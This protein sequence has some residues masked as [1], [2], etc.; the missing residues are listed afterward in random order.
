MSLRDGDVQIEGLSS[1]YFR[2][3]DQ[4]LPR[5]CGDGRARVWAVEVIAMKRL[6]KW[7]AFLAVPLLLLAV[8][9]A[10]GSA[11]K[12][13]TIST[14]GAIESFSVDG[15]RVAF[16]ARGVPPGS[17]NKVLVW[18]VQTR[19]IKRVIGPNTCS[20][21]SSPAGG[22]P[23]L[24]VAGTRIAWIVGGASLGESHESL[25]TASLPRPSERRLEA[26]SGAGLDTEGNPGN[27]IGH[28]VGSGSLIVVNR[29]TTDAAGAVT[30]SELDVVGTKSL[31]RIVSGPDALFASSVD[32]GRIA[33]L[34][35]DGGVGV[36]SGSG[37]LLREVRPSSAKE[38]PCKATPWS[39][40]RRLERWRSTTPAPAPTSVAGRCRSGQPASMSP[41][42]L[43]STSKPGSRPR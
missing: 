11:P 10:S 39:S 4:K 31:R 1:P 15:M 34:R 27:W 6:V 35:A 26:A 2:R 12:P 8:T 9:S 20:A 23:E 19:M 38:S 3:L 22:V 17:C 14:G 25:R 33:V 41:A 13:G 30:R 28:L 40:S 21:D 36:Y 37:R 43:P 16:D 24:A 7:A 32:S 5:C 29:W 42:T 18:N